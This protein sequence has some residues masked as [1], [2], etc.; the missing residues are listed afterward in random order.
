M[1]PIGSREILIARIESGKTPR[2]LHFERW[3]GLNLLGFALMEAR[4]RLGA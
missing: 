3:R 1:E 2:F 4:E